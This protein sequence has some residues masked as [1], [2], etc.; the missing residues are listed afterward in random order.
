M[1]CAKKTR[2]SLQVPFKAGEHRQ[3]AIKVIDDRG[4]ELVAVKSIKEAK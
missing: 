4:N 1:A 3:V 2:T